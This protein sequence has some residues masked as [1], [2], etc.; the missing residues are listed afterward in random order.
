MRLTKLRATGGVKI[1]K[2]QSFTKRDQVDIPVG[3]PPTY[4]NE[5]QP[6]LLSYQLLRLQI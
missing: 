5:S 4:G 3:H 1:K 2:N 6:K